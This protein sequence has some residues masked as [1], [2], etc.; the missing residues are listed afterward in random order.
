MHAEAHV[1]MYVYIL[2]MA[3]VYT[4]TH[5]YTHYT[6]KHSLFVKDEGVSRLDS[7]FIGVLNEL[8]WHVRLC[9]VPSSVAPVWTSLYSDQC[10]GLPTAKCAFPFQ[11]IQFLTLPMRVLQVPHYISS[12][13]VPVISREPACEAE[14]QAL[15]LKRGLDVCLFT[16]PWVILM[17]EFPGEACYQIENSTNVILLRES[18]HHVL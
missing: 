10:T 7:Y 8:F 15:G 14:Y 2:Y 16:S 17:Q 9:A 3:H 5:I 1:Y 4:H 11:G 18:R 12:V 6:Q 13:S